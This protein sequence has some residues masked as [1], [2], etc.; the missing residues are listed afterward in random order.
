L[1]DKGEHH[2]YTP[3]YW[4]A[5]KDKRND[6]RR[7]L[8]VGIGYKNAT[9]NAYWPYGASLRMWEEFL[10]NAEIYG[11]DIHPEVFINEGRIKSLYTDQSSVI[12]LM[13]NIHSLCDTGGPFDLIID[14]GSHILEHQIL[15]ANCY[16]PF[17]AADGIYIIEDVN[18]DPMTVATRLP[19]MYRFEAFKSRA[20]PAHAWVMMI[21]HV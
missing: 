7:V 14:D 6:I 15:T 10:P 16:L 4:E 13:D 21:R 19:P 9:Y 3:V 18:V 2:G 12:S 1:T 8:E 5:L 11:M 20:E 17:L